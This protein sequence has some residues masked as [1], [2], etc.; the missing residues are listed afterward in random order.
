MHTRYVNSLSICCST[1][2]RSGYSG[3]EASLRTRWFHP[4][5]WRRTVYGHLLRARRQM[6]RLQRNRS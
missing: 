5:F 4:R 6:R 2:G 1:V 3:E